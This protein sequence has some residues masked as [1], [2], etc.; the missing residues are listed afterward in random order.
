MGPTSFAKPPDC[1]VYGHAGSHPLDL[2]LAWGARGL[3][4][5]HQQ[6]SHTSGVVERHGKCWPRVLSY[7]WGQMESGGGSGG[8]PSRNKGR[9]S[10]DQGALSLPGLANSKA[11]HGSLLLSFSTPAVFL[12]SISHVSQQAEI[13]QQAKCPNTPLVLGEGVGSTFSNRRTE[14]LWWLE[15]TSCFVG[16]LG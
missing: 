6:R 10:Q 4:G 11:S 5:R 8:T 16:S 1:A 15:A 14:N 7:L 13:S 9:G 2:A 3:A 12:G